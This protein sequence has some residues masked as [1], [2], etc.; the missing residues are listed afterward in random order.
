MVANS[1]TA[2]NR[3]LTI[4]QTAIHVTDLAIEA[5][6]IMTI[7]QPKSRPSSFVTKYIR[8]LDLV[9]IFNVPRFADISSL[10]S[11]RFNSV[12]A[13][14]SCPVRKEP[15]SNAPSSQPKRLFLKPYTIPDGKLIT[16]KENVTCLCLSL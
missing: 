14:N 15:S 12:Y 3:T 7:S 11:T 5:L 6:N 4:Q 1:V 13:L 16:F 10:Y 2:R 9:F 8:F